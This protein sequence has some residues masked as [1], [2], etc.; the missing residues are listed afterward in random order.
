MDDKISDESKLN[1]LLGIYY[2]DRTK[3]GL[4]F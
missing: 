3:M 4:V 2:K 1:V